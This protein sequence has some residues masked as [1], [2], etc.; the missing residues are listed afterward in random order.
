VIIQEKNNVE[1]SNKHE[2]VKTN[3][4]LTVKAEVEAK[5]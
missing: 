5:I 2:D 3:E 4:E 1:A